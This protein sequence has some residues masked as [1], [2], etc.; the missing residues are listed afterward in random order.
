MSNNR[1]SELVYADLAKCVV[2]GPA[3]PLKERYGGIEFG[4]GN[5]CAAIWG[6][7]DKNGVLWLS[8]E[9]YVRAAVPGN[10]PSRLP[11]DVTWYAGPH[12]AG[13]TLLRRAG[14]KVLTTNAAVRTGN[15]AVQAR[16]RTGMLRIVEGACPNLLHEAG[17]YRW[18]DCSPNKRSEEPA[19]DHDYGLK[20]LRHIVVGIDKH[21]PPA[22]SLPAPVK[23]P[24][25]WCNYKNDVLWTTMWP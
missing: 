20:A 25:R 3:S 18:D 12:S 17:R 2:L 11:R 19:E 16:T 15:A 22:P 6:G 5:A 10:H 24:N 1:Q 8:N 23:K 4:A 14:L 13:V 9:Y 21:R 7:L